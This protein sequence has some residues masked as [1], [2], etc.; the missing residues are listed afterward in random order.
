VDGGTEALLFA[1]FTDGA[2]QWKF[3]ESIM[4]SGA[5]FHSFKVS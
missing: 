4:A 3:P 5:R 1:N 2:A